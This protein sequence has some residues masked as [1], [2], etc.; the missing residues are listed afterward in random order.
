MLSELEKNLVRELQVGL[1]LVPRPFAEIAGR[2]KLT[3]TE[4][5][6]KIHEMQAKGYLRR[7]GASLR[8]HQVG[9]AANA[10][11]V[12]CVPGEKL[13]ETGRKFAEYP[14]V[15]HCYQRK[16]SDNWRY[17]LY[18]MLHAQTREECFAL[19]EKLAQAVGVRDYQLLFS[20]KELKK[21]SMMYFMEE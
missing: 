2:L 3:E 13:D 6:E 19:V 4:L 14:E 18:T 12:W 8:H 17:N 20:V 21:S 5:I 10:M 9:Y 1:P 7:I 11:V 16:T 15:T